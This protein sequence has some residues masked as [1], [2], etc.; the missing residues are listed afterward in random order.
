MKQL[1]MF[2]MVIV[3]LATGFILSSCKD[4]KEDIYFSERSELNA[5]N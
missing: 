3:V 1:K 5:K 4:E 2:L